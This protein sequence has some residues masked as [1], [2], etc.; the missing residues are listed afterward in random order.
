GHRTDYLAG[1]EAAL[2][3]FETDS[4]G[5]ACRVLVFF[6]DGLYDP[7]PGR[8]DSEAAVAE[9]IFRPLACTG[10]DNYKSVKDRLLALNIQTYAVLLQQGFQ[11]DSAHEQRM[12]DVS[13]Q[14]LRGLTGDDKSPIVAGLTRDGDPCSHLSGPD[15]AQT[16][17]II[18]V[19]DD[20]MSL[21]NDLLKEIRRIQTFYGCP[22]DDRQ[23]DSWSYQGLPAGLYVERIDLYV[24]GGEIT[25]IRAENKPVPFEAGLVQ[26]HHQDL[27]HL[28][29]GWR[30]EVE[31]LPFPGS[32]AP[33]LECDSYPVTLPQFSGKFP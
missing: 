19:D 1:L 7:L 26:I 29:S 21:V 16:G 4:D 8:T 14:V 27:R 2:G 11:A 31:V 23:A 5:D 10:T 20:I 17:R 33:S 9:G 18:A 6:T 28:P 3:E 13:L 15:A 25:E 32:S 24:E 12:A 30:L 22:G